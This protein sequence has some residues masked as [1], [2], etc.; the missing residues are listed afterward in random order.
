M[1]KTEFNFHRWCIVK[2][3][4]CIDG[5]FILHFFFIFRLLKDFNRGSE[6]LAL[7]LP[8]PLSLSLSL[9]LS[10]FSLIFRK[11]IWPFEK[12]WKKML[13]LWEKFIEI[14]RQELRLPCSGRIIRSCK[15]PIWLDWCFDFKLELLFWKSALKFQ[16]F[17]L[18]E[19]NSWNSWLNSHF[20]R[21]KKCGNQTLSS[22]YL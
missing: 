16:N 4:K 18:G 5:A 12:K 14:A 13:N 20:V 19:W 10:L 1:S 9:S 2:P 22:F 8:L 6:C 15:L 7:A 3:V 17:E 11:I 21:S